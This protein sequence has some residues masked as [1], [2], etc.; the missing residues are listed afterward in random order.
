VYPSEKRRT[1]R[2]AL[3]AGALFAAAAARSASAADAPQV[4]RTIGEI[5]ALSAQDAAKSLPVRLE[6]VV[7]YYHH[8]WDML[9]VQDA[10]GGIFVYVDHRAPAFPVREGQRVELSGTTAS[11]DF[12]PSIA[13]PQLKAIATGEFPRPLRATLKDIGQGIADSAWTEVRGIVRSAAV[14]DDVLEIALMMP[15]GGLKVHVKHFGDRTDFGALVD[16]VVR[17]QGVCSTLANEQRQFQG[18]EIWVPDLERQVFVEQAAPA[19]PFEAPTLPIEALRRVAFA[20][21][22]ER[23]LKVSGTVTLHQPGRGVFIQDEKNGLFVEAPGAKALRPGDRVAAVGF[24]GLRGER[25]VLEEALVQRLEGGGA[26]VPAAVTAEQAARPEHDS[27]LVSVNG[28]FVGRVTLAGQESL[29]FQDGGTVFDIVPGGPLDATFLSLEP[30]STAQLTGVTTPSS[31]PGASQQSF[32]LLLRSPADLTVLRRG[33]WWTATR[34]R[35]FLLVLSGAIVVALCWVALLRRRVQKQTGIIQQRLERETALEQRYRDLVENA[36]DVVFSLDATGRILSLNAAAESILGRPRTALVGKTLA[37]IASAPQ[38]KL[39]PDPNQPGLAPRHYELEAVTADGRV[40]VLEVNARPRVQDG[41]VVGVEGIARDVTERKRAEAQ[42]RRKE[43]ALRE[44]QERFSLA[45]QGTNDGIW[46]WDLRT[47]RLYFSPRWKSMLG[48]G[49]EEVGQAAEDWFRLV[50][51]DDLGRLKEKLALHRNNLRPHFEDEHRMLHKD[52]SYRWVLCRG[53]ALRQENGIA[54][55]MAGA[56]TDVTDRR[57]YDPLTGLA[58]RALFAE[59]LEKAVRR[60][61]HA[62]GYLFAVLFLDLDRFKLVNDSLGHLAGDALLVSIAR[63]L[64]GCVRPSDVIA[65][66]GGDEFA[67]LVDGLAGPGD[68]VHVAD[69]IQEALVEPFNLG[70]HEV[71]ATGSIGISLSATGYEHAEDLLRDADTAMY[72]AKA[73]GRARYEMFDATM[74]EQVTVFLRTE[75]DLRRAL[76]RDELRLHYLP[77]VDLASGV[78]VALEALVRWQHPERG[79][80][81]PSGF[82]DVAEETGLV[83]PVGEWVLRRACRDAHAWTLP[84]GAPGPSVCVNVSSRQVS[85]LELPRRVREA[86][87]AAELPPERLVLEMTES[88]VMVSADA[89]VERIAALKKLGVRLYLDDFGTGYSSLSYLYRLPIDAV[90]IDRSFV[91]QMADSEEARTIVHSILSLASNLELGV[92]AEGVETQAQRMALRALGCGQAQGFL[93]SPPLEA[94]AVAALLQAHAGILITEP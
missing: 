52:G 61:K 48:Y 67:V 10:T 54:H 22:Y 39:L 92:I 11:G 32:Q 75:N 31:R 12:L 16:S 56:Q 2:G 4:I 8:D 87:E 23:R 34:A 19:D 94:A 21:G 41:R 84:G 50:H 59:R 71:Y 27:R 88:A 78:I 68:V 85:D 43:E 6:A 49:E 3:L 64:E 24:L 9:F 80:L 89:V 46:D 5:H 26:P 77:V 63:R 14:V 18:A 36:N 33:S 90:K 55:R 28:E 13:S 40:A 7:T 37:D 93:F 82:V 58:N 25:H 57:S 53:F 69:R 60:S 44:S 29:V 45:V 51:P 91:S 42:L 70:G 73:G 79:L 30:G 81:P 66:F 15:G 74:R 65:R 38:A 47:D 62:P 72:R 86:L 17:V 1:L 20:G 35:T 83:V 76:E